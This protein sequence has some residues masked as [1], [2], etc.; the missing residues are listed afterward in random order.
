M[1]HHPQTLVCGQDTEN[2]EH[3]QNVSD[4]RLARLT[5]AVQIPEPIYP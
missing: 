3:L 1:L 4:V 2:C 5:V